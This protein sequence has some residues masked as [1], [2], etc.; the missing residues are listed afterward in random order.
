MGYVDLLIHGLWC[1]YG[2]YNLNWLTIMILT[3]VQRDI[4]VFVVSSQVG[5]LFTIFCW[6]ILMDPMLCQDDNLWS[7]FVDLLSSFCDSTPPAP[8]LSD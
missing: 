4:Q 7:K 1:I 6:E 3:S 2:G 5:F 8:T